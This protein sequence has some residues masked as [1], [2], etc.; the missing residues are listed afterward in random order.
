M[1]LLAVRLLF[2]R[3]FSIRSIFGRGLRGYQTRNNSSL[4]IFFTS[5]RLSQK[6]AWATIQ[7]IPETTIILYARRQFGIVLTEAAKRRICQPAQRAS[8][9]IQMS[10]SAAYEREPDRAAVVSDFY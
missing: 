9:W 10:M 8:R 5:N 7:P 3:R 2:G 1:S 6:L 4:P